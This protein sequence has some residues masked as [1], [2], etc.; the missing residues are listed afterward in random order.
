MPHKSLS[1]RRFLQTSIG[2]P[3]LAALAAGSTAAAAET[4]AKPVKKRNSQASTLKQLTK[5]Q[6][7]K[8]S[9]MSRTLFPHDLLDDVVY[10][11]VVDS[12]DADMNANSSKK[13]LVS[14]GL[15][16]LG[17]DFLVSNPRNREQQLRKIESSEFFKYVHAQTISHIYGNPE[18]WPVFGFEGSSLERGGYIDRGFNDIDWLPPA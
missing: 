6:A 13:K 7:V 10:M 1:R 12:I 11:K 5:Q 16:L 4:T 18:L 3:A 2:A 8:I 14:E 15:V 17:D 9:A